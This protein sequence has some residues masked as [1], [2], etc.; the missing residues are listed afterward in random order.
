MSVTTT[1]PLCGPANLAVDRSGIT[2]ELESLRLLLLRA[3]E[4]LGRD[5][6]SQ[7]ERTCNDL[8][9]RSVDLSPAFGEL[10]PNRNGLS[11]VESEQQC[12]RLLVPLLEARAFYLAALRRWRRNLFLR[13]S[14]MKMQRDPLA[15]N[16]ADA[17]GWY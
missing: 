17:S 6:A 4:A 14:L 2:V 15:N 5:D 9:T 8:H 1:A 13:R 3:A 11:P 16:G 10:L 7:V 12:R